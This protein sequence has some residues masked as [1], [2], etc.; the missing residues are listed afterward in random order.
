MANLEEIVQMMRFMAEN[1][2]RLVDAQTQRLLREVIADCS[3]E[4]GWAN[5][6]FVGAMLIQ[7][8]AD[9]DTRS[10]GFKKLSKLLTSGKQREIYEVKDTESGKV[11]GKVRVTEQYK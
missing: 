7:R 8:K 5:L 9:F 4:D 6:A 2:T 11:N 1:I 10:F 3:D